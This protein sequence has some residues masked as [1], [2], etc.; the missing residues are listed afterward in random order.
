MG[1]SCAYNSTIFERHESEPTV[2]GSAPVTSGSS[3]LM[4]QVSAEQHAAQLHVKTPSCGA[5][6][7]IEKA[8][9]SAHRTNESHAQRLSGGIMGKAAPPGASASAVAS[10][11]AHCKLER[12]NQYDLAPARQSVNATYLYDLQRRPDGAH[13]SAYHLKE[14]SPKPY[15]SPGRT[16]HNTVERINSSAPDPAVRICW[17][18]SGKPV[19]A[20]TALAAH[21][22]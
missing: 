18:V 7:F 13:V 2:A 9:T 22:M 15:H 20:C 16:Y 8:S 12:Y 10:A 11:P 6:L 17:S 4:A 1:R 3:S 21:G 19:S 5:L 14:S